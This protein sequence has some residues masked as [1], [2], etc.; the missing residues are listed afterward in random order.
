MYVDSLFLENPGTPQQRS[1]SPRRK[2]SDSIRS[3][4]LEPARGL[5]LDGRIPNQYPIQSWPS[6]VIFMDIDG[7]FLT[8]KKLRL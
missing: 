2:W 7:L 6:T 4:M 8:P 3:W 1:D 5:W